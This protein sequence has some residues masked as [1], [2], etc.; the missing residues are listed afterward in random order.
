MIF[1]FSILFALAFFSTTYVMPHSI[2]KLR[3]NKYLVKDMYKLETPLIPTNGGMILVFTSF[4]AV[5][6]MPLLVR[7]FSFSLKIEFA[8]SDLSESH[9]AMLLVVSVYALYGLVDD[10][11]DIGRILKLILPIT[12]AFPLISVIKPSFFPLIFY[13]DIDLSIF[14]F[15]DITRSDI[16]RITIIPIYVMVVSNLVN[17]HSGYNGLQSGLSII[18]LIT[19]CLK[20]YLDG[21]LSNIIPVAS[22]LGS[23]CAFLFFNIYPSKIF[24]GNI[25]SL[26]FGSTIGCAI[27]LQEYW[28]FG[29]F[30]MIPH[31]LNFI[32]WVIW[33][34]LMRVDSKAYL[35]QDGTHQKFGFVG[36]DGKIDAPNNLTLKWMVSNYFKATEY[37]SVI[38]LYSITIIFCLGGLFIA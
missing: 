12:F 16:F 15:G 21:I 31:T 30:I 38:I 9:L 13:G 28:W 23:M 2:R 18:L 35:K 29:F 10:L 27:V 1:L 6:L 19:I 4:T 37:Q 20:S 32:L 14:L 26:F 17:M 7:F 24:E 22:I 8:V 25:G 3:E 5:S 36:Q 34:C 33:L 11:V